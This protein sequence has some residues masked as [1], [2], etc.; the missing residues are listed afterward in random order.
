M[1]E[2]WRI[3]WHLEAQALVGLINEAA[4]N[5]LGP[6]YTFLK[7]QQWNILKVRV[8]EPAES[9]ISVMKIFFPGEIINRDEEGVFVQTGNG[10]LKLLVIQKPGAPIINNFAN[11]QIAEEL[12]LGSWFDQDE[13]ERAFLLAKP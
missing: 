13:Y 5:K 2:S 7:N 12:H 8:L 6:A 10:I 11:R 9:F 3:K 4:S 1:T